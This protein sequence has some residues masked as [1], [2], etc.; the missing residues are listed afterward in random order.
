[1]KF[2]QLIYYSKPFGFS[3]EL[4]SA[5]LVVSRTNNEERDITG[6]LIC[7]SDIFLQLL[8]GPKTQVMKTYE[9]IQRDDRHVNICHLMD[10]MVDKRLFPAWAMRDDPVKTWMWSRK[11]VANGIVERLSKSEVEDIFVKL[12]KEANIFSF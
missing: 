7:R 3:L 9:A 4:L 2:M 11:E 1:M 6:A 10:K 5:I 12:S 8:E